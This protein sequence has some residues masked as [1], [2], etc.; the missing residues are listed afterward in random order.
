MKELRPDPPYPSDYKSFGTRVG[1]AHFRMRPYD[2]SGDIDPYIIG[3]Y[4]NHRYPYGSNG[5]SLEADKERSER[6]CEGEFKFSIT[7]SGCQDTEVWPG[8]EY[9]LDHLF[10][11]VA[12]L[13]YPYFGPEEIHKGFNIPVDPWMNRLRFYKT[14]ELYLNQYYSDYE[15]AYYLFDEL[16]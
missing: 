3:N 10:Y 1:S 11:D 9:E 4:Y 8:K 16:T 13:S 14:H 12:C 6:E 15:S 7:G 2:E 5:A